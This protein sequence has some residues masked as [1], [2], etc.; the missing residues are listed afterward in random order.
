M[1]EFLGVPLDCPP[2]GL[3][4]ERSGAD[5]NTPPRLLPMMDAT[6]RVATD[7]PAGPT[8]EKFHGTHDAPYPSQSERGYV[9][10]RMPNARLSFTLPD[11]SDQVKW[12]ALSNTLEH[13]C[14]GAMQDPVGAR[15]MDSIHL[16]IIDALTDSG[17]V[18]APKP[19]TGAIVRDPF[20]RDLRK[21]K[22]T[23]KEA[24][25]QAKQ[26][27]SKTPAVWAAV[28]IQKQV[29]DSYQEVER[30]RET[31]RNHHL[32]KT[33]PKKLANAIWGRAMSSEPPDCS[34]SDCEA[35]FHDV[36]KQD[37]PPTSNPSWL[38]PQYPA[39]PLQPLVITASMVA[40]A[41]KKKGSKRSS[42]GL[43]GI[44]YQLL[45]KLPWAPKALANIFNNIISQQSAPEI[46]RYGVTVLLHK[47][48]EKTLANY[49]PIT[50]TATI[51]KLF[52]SI[53]AAWLERAIIAAGI[54]ST[55]VQKG[56]L[57]G[58]SGAIEH[59]LVLDEVLADAKRHQKPLFMLLVDLKN[60]FGSVPHSRIQW[61]L[62][63]FGVPA[64]VKHYI[65]NFYA[66]VQTQLHCKAW[67]TAYLQV[68]RGVLQGD[69]LSPLLF[70]LVMQVALDALA[71]TCPG[72]GYVASKSPQHHFLKCF[73]DDLTVIT[74]T[75]KQLQLAVDKLDQITDWLG[76]Q[77]KPSKCRTFGLS[78]GKYR[79]V[80]ILIYGQTI[81]NVEDAPSKFLGMELSLT[82]SFK[83]KSQIAAKALHE[84][85]QPLESFPL[86][87]RDKVQIY[88]S[89]AIP[90]M[91][92]ILLVQD[93]LP[94]ALRR[95]T[96]QIE[97]YVKRWWHLPR[98][99][100]RAALCLLTGIPPITDIAMQTQLTKY[101]IAQASGDPNVIS[102]LK[103][104]Q[105][106]KHK[107]LHRLLKAFGG[108]LPQNRSE[109]KTQLR[110]TQC[111]ELAAV[112]GKLLVQGA[113]SR[114]DTSLQADK[115]WR[116]T[117][118]SLPTDV[119]QFATK[120][121][122]DV[123]PTRANLLRWRVGCDSACLHCGVKETLHHTLNNCARLL[124][125]GAYTWRH[126][127]VLQHLAPQIESKHP[128]SQIQIDLPDRT[129]QLPFHC[130]TAW[131]PDIVILHKDHSIDFVEL[132]IPFEPNTAAAHSRK[133]SKYAP[134]LQ[135]AKMEGLI[136]RLYCI[137]MGSRGIPSPGWEKWIST[138]NKPLRITKECSS[139]ALR[140]SHVVWL[141]R[142]TAWPNPP[143]LPFSVETVEQRP[144]HIR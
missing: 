36:F 25:V 119:Q 66:N 30:A 95:I 140:T 62:S 132:T 115:H 108:S 96:C 100:S 32:A 81:L 86:P 124:D 105:N 139:L 143:L 129:Y 20:G 67:T 5:V 141:H 126:N 116:S 8:V 19:K 98:A 71:T 130:D 48:G 111:K 79:K 31:R 46:W 14:Q 99:T 131:R 29:A 13:A 103:Q 57:L 10:S 112:V 27:P 45:A 22:S 84:I 128:T 4:P 109:G 118:W 65:H 49:R 90:K 33:N 50:L 56:F 133:T 114:L 47:G 138:L 80:E 122:L 28:K 38:P 43:D 144:K 77:I 7:P 68:R 2:K 51:S 52:H 137:E 106:N 134:L 73:A 61:A 37:A 26:D 24:R 97:G 135:Q 94:T 83:E 69:T 72:Y 15:A 74:K 34:S 88:K 93:V 23:V 121:A 82:Q 53:I 136:P 59:D 76:M 41:I 102:V 63:R 101:T 104:R 142:A 60:A 9:L 64:W 11:A 78:K 12:T 113:W 127:S 91:R 3:E 42:P 18:E 58:V 110:Q 44:T 107:P 6:Q 17:L 87:N 35:F 70:L 125:A 123:L 54:I 21:A 75:P 40:R 55:S 89:F 92:W 117:M 85:I 39:L 1:L 16:S 120:A